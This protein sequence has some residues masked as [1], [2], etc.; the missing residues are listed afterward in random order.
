MIVGLDKGQMG[1]GSCLVVAVGIILR[2]D[3]DSAYCPTVV[4]LL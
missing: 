1:R 2:R 3:Y 4:V